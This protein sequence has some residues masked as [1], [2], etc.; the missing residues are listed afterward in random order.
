MVI[1]WDNYGILLTE[2]LSRG[3][4]I[5]GSYYAPIIE[6]LHCVIVEKHHGK[7]S[8]EVLLLHDNTPVHKCNIVQA[9]IRKAGFVELNH[10]VYSPGIGSSDY[11]LFSKLKKFLR[12]KNFSRD[13]ETI[14]TVKDYL[15][16]LD[17]QFFCKGID[18]LHD[19]WQR[20]V[21]SEGQYID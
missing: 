11:Y 4:R 7:V 13:D 19:R 8:D 2:Y 16:K 12:G 6:R 10:P 21:A 17:W 5:G 3:T 20:V 18:S 9:A 1:F 15:N 14:D